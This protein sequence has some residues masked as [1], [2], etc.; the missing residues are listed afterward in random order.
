MLTILL[1][2]ISRVVSDESDNLCLANPSA[3]HP[4][5]KGGFFKGEGLLTQAD[6]PPVIDIFTKEIANLPNQPS[7][8]KAPFF[9][10]KA[11]HICWRDKVIT[12]KGICP[13]SIQFRASRR[14]GDFFASSEIFMS[15]INTNKMINKDSISNTVHPVPAPFSTNALKSRSNNEGGNNQKDTLF[16]RGNRL[17]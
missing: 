6:C 12:G 15:I 11:S 8:S 5:G 10:D 16:N 14:L 13:N 7:C 4:L 1:K 2:N 9:K 17:S 3:T